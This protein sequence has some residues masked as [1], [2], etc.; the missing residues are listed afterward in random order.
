MPIS[1]DR[2]VS[3]IRQ[4][5]EEKL[6]YSE[7]SGRI[8]AEA[9]LVGGGNIGKM[10]VWKSAYDLC[11]AKQKVPFYQF[12]AE[13]VVEKFWAAEAGFKSLLIDSMV[14][15]GKKE[16]VTPEAVCEVIK[17]YFFEDLEK[18][19]LALWGKVA[20]FTPRLLAEK[21]EDLPWLDEVFCSKLVDLSQRESRQCKVVMVDKES[22]ELRS[23]LKEVIDRKYVAEASSQDALSSIKKRFIYPGA[24]IGR[25]VEVLRVV[26]DICKGVKRYEVEPYS[27]YGLMIQECVSELAGIRGKGSRSKVEMPLGR[28]LLEEKAAEDQESMLREAAALRVREEE[29]K[30]A[31]TAPSRATKGSFES[32]EEYMTGGTDMGSYGEY[33]E[34]VGRYY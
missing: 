27:F 16:P 28:R 11:Y 6:P 7:L 13:D 33:L 26:R 3:I 15:A 14:A 31:S 8:D 4:H 24:D 10:M 12:F 32:W 18:F 22:E 5:Q 29:T 30:V 23:D 20:E 2:V 21:I 17:E 1:M 25:C 34:E 9:M 19:P